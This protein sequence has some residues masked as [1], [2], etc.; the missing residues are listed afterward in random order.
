MPLLLSR[1]DLR[2]LA[3]DDA[4]LDQAI[5]AV[6]A[7][8]LRSDAG[9]RGQT[10]F[11][12]LTLPNGEE[13]A[14]QLVTRAS[15]PA[16]VRIFPNRPSH[17][18][19]NA[20]LGLQINGATGEI[21]S[22][23]AMDDLNP[24]RTA[25]PAAVGVRHLAP[26]ESNVLTVLGSGRQAYSHARVLARVLPKLTEIRVWSPTR[27]NRERFGAT[28]TTHQLAEHVSVRDTLESAVDG[29]DVITATGLYAAG[30]PAVPDHE[31]VRAGALL[32]SMTGAGLNLVGAGARRVVPPRQRPELVAVGVASGFRRG[33]GPAAQPDVVELSDV[34]H[35]RAVPRH[36]PAE[37]VVF[38]LAAPYAWDVPILTWIHDWATSRGVGTE[39]DFSG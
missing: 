28:L 35:G 23:M 10:V 1:S 13:I 26:P 33:G 8:V 37:T 4:A 20:W 22:M 39:F 7:S 19:R 3:G 9:D 31:L 29:A 36:S 12:G 24:L 2:P 14:T 32:V 5:D 6:E 11:A 18:V 21:A 15:G 17:D 25:V 38:E 30:E 16:S 27:E 34:I